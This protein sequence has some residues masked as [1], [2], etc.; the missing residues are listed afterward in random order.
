[1]NPLLLK[2]CLLLNGALV[3]EADVLVLGYA[4]KGA[5][6]E[7]QRVGDAGLQ[8]LH[9]F[10]VRQDAGDAVPVATVAFPYLNVS[11]WN[12]RQ[13]LLY[14]GMEVDSPPDRRCTKKVASMKHSRPSIKFSVT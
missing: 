9:L 5:F 3:L 12:S 14:A 8:G 11:S 7:E 4:V 2:K 10:H 13:V 6:V 1:M